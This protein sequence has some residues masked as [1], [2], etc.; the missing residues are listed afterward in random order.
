MSI[1]DQVTQF[2]GTMLPTNAF[3]MGSSH[4]LVFLACMFH[5]KPLE[6]IIKNVLVQ[7]TSFSW[8]I[9]IVLDLLLVWNTGI[10]TLL[11]I[12]PAIHPFLLLRSLKCCCQSENIEFLIFSPGGTGHSRPLFILSWL[13]ILFNAC[14]NHTGWLIMTFWELKEADWRNC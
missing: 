11:S 10:K 2:N 1:P 7:F 13:L 8:S 4:G 14:L 3:A 12:P 9:A 6:N 5:P